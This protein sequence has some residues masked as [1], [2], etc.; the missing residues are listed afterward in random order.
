MSL[1]HKRAGASNTMLST[2]E[3]PVSRDPDPNESASLS[4]AVVRKHIRLRG[5]D[6]SL[7]HN[8]LPGAPLY[9]RVLHDGAEDKSASLE[10][11]CFQKLSGEGKQLQ[12]KVCIYR[13]IFLLDKAWIIPDFF[14]SPRTGQQTDHHPSSPPILP[15]C[16]IHINH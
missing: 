5:R 10:V 2:N 12:K 16:K 8:P 11:C 3:S 13:N 7:A 4:L 6:L 1:W 15:L 14:T 9:R